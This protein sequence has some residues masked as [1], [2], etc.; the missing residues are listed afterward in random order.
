MFSQVH[1]QATEFAIVSVICLQY[2]YFLLCGIH[3]Y[4]VLGLEKVFYGVWHHH[5]RGNMT[6]AVRCGLTKAPVLN[7]F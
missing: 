3:Q 4:L 2:S 7:L 1:I 5:D 6:K